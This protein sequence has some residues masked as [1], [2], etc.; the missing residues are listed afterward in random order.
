MTEE[1]AEIRSRLEQAGQ[2]HL[3]AFWD[4][5]TAQQQETLLEQLAGICLDELADLTERYVTNPSPPAAEGD[6]EITPPKIFPH[7]PADD[8]QAELY[9]RATARGNELLRE[10]KVAAFVVAGGQGTRLGFDGP[11][12]CFQATPVAKKPLFQVFAEQIQ[13]AARRAGAPIRWYV[14]TSPINDTQTR[15]FFRRNHYF[16][17]DPDSVRFCVQDTMPAIGLDGKL[18]LAAKGIVAVSPN[19]HGGSLTAMRSG[20]ALDEMAREGIELISYFQVDNPLVRCIDPLFLG[21]HDLHNAEVSAKALPKRDPME[22]VGNFCAV[23]GR[24]T[25]IEYTDMP[26]ELARATTEEGYL[27]FSAGSIAIHV[28]SR[29]FVERL[30]SDGKCALPY[31]RAKKKV[32]YIDADGQK[33]KPDKPNAVK[34]EMF[35][36][37]AMPLANETLILETD[38]AEEFSPVKNAEG[39]DSLVTSLHDQVRRAANWLEEAGI[40]LPLDADGQVAAAIEISPLFADSAEEF[41]AKIDPDLTISGGQQLYLGSRGQI[42]GTK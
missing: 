6:A 7:K 42:G 18:L 29:S 4:K 32:K 27:K 13:A 8:E 12:G 24:T 30:T 23:D 37:D 41:A 28:F 15:A 34:L 26:E 2:A 25:V 3:L 40:E 11:K 22:P 35:V 33:V 1:I 38:R 14:M 36:F 16:A 10:G 17:L 39:P 21:L 9:A 31:H 20:G 19:G 5:L